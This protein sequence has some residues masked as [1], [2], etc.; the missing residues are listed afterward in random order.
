ELS[1]PFRSSSGWHLILFEE[2]RQADRTEESLRAEARDMIAQQKS[3]A[4]IERVLR[5]FR[6]E[7]YVDIRL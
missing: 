7:A 4:E 2:E 5:Q 3:Q 1:P 6:D